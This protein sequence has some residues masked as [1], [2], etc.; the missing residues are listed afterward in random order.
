MNKRIVRKPVTVTKEPMTIDKIAPVINISETEIEKVGTQ[1]ENN[2]HKTM[3]ASVTD[4]VF[5]LKFI[6][7][8]LY[9]FKCGSSGEV[10][11]EPTRKLI[12][13]I[14]IGYRFHSFDSSYNRGQLILCF[15]KR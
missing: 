10:I 1:I 7:I 15:E 13:E 9:A 5:P 3:Q 4:S 14:L 11:H 6:E 8:P 2:W 12:D